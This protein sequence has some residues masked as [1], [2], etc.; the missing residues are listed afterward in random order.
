MRIPQ[1]A[2]AAALG[3]SLALWTCADA[4]SSVTPVAASQ[5]TAPAPA[6]VSTPMP[7][8]TPSTAPAEGVDELRE[9]V[10][11]IASPSMKGRGAGSPELD[12]ARDIVRAR[13]EGAGL[14]PG[15]GAQ[16]LQPF[17]GPHGEKLANV[18]GRTGSGEEWI[19]IGAHYDGL[20]VGAPGTPD[21]GQAFLGAD[22]NASGV[23]A[24]VR[25]GHALAA[26]KDLQRTVY[27][28]AF[29][30]EELGTLGS[31]WLVE[32]PPSELSKCVAMLNMD[33]VGR[34]EENKL[35][36]FGTGTAEEFESIL[37]G[38][39]LGFGFDFAPN[40][41][42]PGASDQT[43]F[44]EKGIPVLHFFSGAKPEYHRPGDR[45]EL[46]NF[47]GLAKVADY[48]G[49]VAA[50]VATTQEPLTFRAAGAEHLS[51]P[52]GSKP[53]KVSL[54]TIPDFSKE[55]GGILLSGVM[56]GSPAEVAGL[57]AGDLITAM[58]GQSI[59]N[60]YDFQGVLAGHAPGDVVAV[61]YVRG[62][63]KREAKVTL[64]E[65]H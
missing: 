21:A 38:V 15:L 48:V 31:K 24:L 12:R 32:H 27:L 2:L 64:A 4:G 57:A 51:A 49:E 30:G 5:G 39:N 37:K 9:I 62:K 41:G 1:A 14:S 42:G 59:D 43:P 13:F 25:I 36:V 35:I 52:P 65:R 55:S 60:I 6:A 40:S 54:G 53:R 29:S 28:V 10:G 56:P 63:E 50:Y 18:V 47:D 19:V 46:L 34:V 8:P 26:R 44:F 45:I 23:A 7:M 20:G 58:D 61:T 22:D 3:L 17:D 16:W 33:C 11:A